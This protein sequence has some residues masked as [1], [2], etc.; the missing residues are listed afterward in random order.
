MIYGVISPEGEQV[1][2]F[3]TVQSRGN[4]EIWL[5]VLQKELVESLKRLTKTGLFDYMNGV[6]KTRN[7]WILQHRSQVVSVVS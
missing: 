6:Q 1:G 5:D 2:L 7:E 3:K 4:V